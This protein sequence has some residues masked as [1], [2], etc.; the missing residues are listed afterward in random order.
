MKTTGQKVM[1]LM[2]ALLILSC[3]VFGTAALVGAQDKTIWIALVDPFSGRGA[4]YGR[5]QKMGVD[6]ALEEINAK[7][8]VNGYKFACEIGDDR[9]ENKEAANLAKKF[10]SDPK[11]KVVIGSI[12]TPTVFAAAPIYERGKLPYIVS[13]ASHPDIAKQGKYIFQNDLNMDYEPMAAAQYAIKNLGL[14]KIAFMYI[15]DDWGNVVKERF[16]KAVPKLGGEIVASEAY[17]PGEVDFK[18]LII[19]V[20]DKKPDI[21]YLAF[22]APEAGQLVRQARDL[23]VSY[24]IYASSAIGTKTFI[25]LGGPAAQGIIIM[26]GFNE[27]DQDPVVQNFVKKFQ[28]KFNEVPSGFSVY[29]YDSCYLIAEAVK[30]IKGE[31]TRDAIANALEALKDVRLI[32]GNV[33]CNDHYF[34]PRKV[35]ATVVKDNSFV[36]QQEIK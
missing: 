34:S 33:S 21:L 9:M 35:V 14:K 7:G 23:N 24:P 22:L 1:A 36:F 15:N 2:G 19:K 3:F 4:D 28:A 20:T 6:L 31:P 16:L 17:S 25:E 27:G 5:M 32:V 11:I 26:S 29:A 12:N 10:V 30:N 18:N 13:W 8:G